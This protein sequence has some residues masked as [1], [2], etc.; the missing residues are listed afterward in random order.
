MRGEWTPGVGVARARG[1]RGAFTSGILLSCTGS[2]LSPSQRMARLHER[3]MQLSSSTEGA[4][5]V[6]RADVVQIS[7]AERATRLHMRAAV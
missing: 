5:V 2:Y 3:G 4:G 1:D 7:A 6:E